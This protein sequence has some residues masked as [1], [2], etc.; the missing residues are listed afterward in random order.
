[1]SKTDTKYLIII[2]GPTAIGKTD[3]SLRIAQDLNAHIFS[4]DSRQIYKE[5]NIGTAKPS[6]KELSVVPHHFI[7][8]VSIQDNYSVGRYLREFD[9]QIESYFQ[10]H[11]VAILTGGTGLYIKAILEG[12]NEF[13]DTKAEDVDYYESLLRTEGIEPLQEELKSKDPEYY[14]EVDIHNGARL[15]RALSLMKSSEHPFS[16][17]RNKKVDRNLP[18]KVV[19]I[20]LQRDRA[21]LYNRIESRVDLMLKKGLL[22]EVKDLISLK[23]HRALDTVGYSELFSYL[24]GQIDLEE[25][26]RLIKRNSR[27]YAKRQ[28]TWFKNQGDFHAFHP[29]AYDEIKAFITEEM[30]KNE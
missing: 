6:Q 29:E 21:T 17:Y 28:M 19:P 9:E 22:D 5:M 14:Q 25:A 18:F 20:V 23:D 2:A 26:I 11:D 15:I 7:D 24:D 16:Y 8:H 1:M 27:R 30:K 12:I 10:D 13:P 3:L 4:C